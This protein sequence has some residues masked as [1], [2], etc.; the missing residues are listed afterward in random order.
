MDSERGPTP[1]QHV[2]RQ[3]RAPREKIR[4]QS[5][6]YHNMYIQYVCIC[7]A[8]AV[9]SGEA[10]HIRIIHTMCVNFFVLSFSKTS[11]SSAMA[12]SKSRAVSRD[13]LK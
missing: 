8:L 5:E 7:S 10:S 2:V 1:P 3:W 12:Y 9:L 6:H 11:L 4:D 13:Q